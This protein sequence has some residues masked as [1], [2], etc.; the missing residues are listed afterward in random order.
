MPNHTRK[1]AQ[2]QFNPDAGEDYPL[3]LRAAREKKDVRRVRV[4]SR[5]EINEQKPHLVHVAAKVFASE[6]VAEFVD[7]A[8]NHQKD[9]EHPDV[10]GA[11]VCEIV[12]RR[13]VLLY[14]RPIAGKQVAGDDEYAERE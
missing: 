9:P 8:K 4:K 3:A 12:E 2:H 5:G 13:G 11:L 14:A 10:V 7:R 6:A 1:P